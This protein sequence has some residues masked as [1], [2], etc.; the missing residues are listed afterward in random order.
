MT[1]KPQIRSTRNRAVALL[2][3]DGMQMLDVAGPADVFA[4]ANRRRPADSPGY[5]VVL[6]SPDGGVVRAASGIAIAETTPLSALRG[7]IDTLVVAG[8]SEA[9]R[10]DVAHDGRTARWLRRRARSIRRV[11]SVCTGAF[12]LADAGLLA[13]RRVATH[14]GSCAALAQVC[15]EATVEPDAIFVADPPIFT[16]AGVT[17]AIDLCLA[18][19]EADLGRRVALAVARD[20]VLFLRRPGGQSQFSA[21]LSAQAQASDRLCDLIT[22]IQQHP[23][24]DLRVDRLARR[25][26]MGL[27]NFARVFRRETGVPPAR[28]VEAVRIERAK[29]YLEDT[30]WALAQVA[31]RS[32]LGSE[33]SLLRGFRR[34]LGVTPRDYR[35]RFSRETIAEAR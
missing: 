26:A 18:L 15:P 19:V 27:R 10:H 8:G 12:L 1:K 34:R 9:G 7:P 6:V 33:D 35:A 16:S 31:Q 29:L 22:W 5:R 13:G 23:E 17:A 32:G 30:D 14:W 2:V 28:F 24:S 4:A 21:A 11:C 20:L 25:V 3:Y